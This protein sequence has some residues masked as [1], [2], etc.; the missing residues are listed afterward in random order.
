MIL[1][2]YGKTVEFTPE[3]QAVFLNA[4]LD[5]DDSFLSLILAGSGIYQFDESATPEERHD[6]CLDA[7]K[8]YVEM[9]LSALKIFKKK[10]K[11]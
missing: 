1:N 6:I 11:L 7:I 10:K 4:G 2:V 8:E 3:E 5:L 9:T